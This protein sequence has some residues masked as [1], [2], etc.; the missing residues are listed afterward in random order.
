MKQKYIELMEKALSAY[1]DGHYRVFLA[2]AEDILNVKIEI[3]KA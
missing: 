3:L 1:T 2:T